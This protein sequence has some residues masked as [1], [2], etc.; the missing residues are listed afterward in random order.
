MHN[1]SNIFDNNLNMGLPA[2]VNP[3][4]DVS[5]TSDSSITREDSTV[6]RQR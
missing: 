6:M 2:A 5:K 1:S 4:N 3:E